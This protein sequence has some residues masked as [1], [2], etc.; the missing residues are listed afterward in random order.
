MKNIL[1]ALVLIPMLLQAQEY[2]NSVQNEGEYLGALTS[3]TPEWFKESFL[4][5]A[6]DVA[7]A[8]EENKRVMLYFH[9]PGCPYCAKLVNENFTD[10]NIKSY[11]QDNFDGITI[12]MWG[13]REIVS[14]GD[15][16]YT[17]KEFS[18]A[19]K[20]QYTPTILFLNEQ[21]KTA[22]R[23]NGY[24]SPEKF[25]GALTYVAEHLEKKQSFNEYL[26][27]NANVEKQN[28]MQHEN[29]FIK[30]LDLN[31]LRLRSNNV[32]AVYFEKNNCHDCQI[33]HDKVLSDQTTRDIVKRFNNIQV[34]ALSTDKIVIPSGET[35]TISNWAKQLNIAYY[36]SV[37]FF[38]TQGLEVMR[39]GGFLK[40]FHFQS[41]YD[42][43][44]EKAYLTEPSF[45]RY[46]ADRGEKIRALGFN[47]DIWG[48]QSEYTL[49]EI[50]K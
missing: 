28:K 1:I 18:L 2:S 36:P 33:I 22:L 38:D 45:Q 24:Y 20:V 11:I 23:L 40:S 14:V 5:F 37:V 17:E 35:L 16:T 44:Y 3:E 19:L 32:T 46:I 6:E 42:Y 9:Q 15:K 34:N 12:N 25:R 8:A 10:S 26:K 43:V 21:G 41:V 4:E 29:F 7:E 39:I 47:T 48:Y 30:S 13:D 50:T 31:K 27:L 49:N